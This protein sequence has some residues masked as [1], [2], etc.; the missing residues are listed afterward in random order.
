[1]RVP[2]GRSAFAALLTL[3][4]CS[5]RP[6]PTGALA[7]PVLV[8]ESYGPAVYP[9]EVAFCT[10]NERGQDRYR[11]MVLM[12]AKGVRYSVAT[13]IAKS[14]DKAWIFDLAGN[15]PVHMEVTLKREEAMSLAQAKSWIAAHVQAKWSYLDLVEG[16]HA[17]A[18]AG[19][20]TDATFDSILQRFA[21]PYSARSV[22]A[23]AQ[24]VAD[25]RAAEWLAQHPAGKPPR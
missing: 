20:Q 3:L 12:D 15:A 24:R 4:G 9:D 5:P 13:A 19:L 2:V 17:R 11:S 16:G 6:V 14:R 8:L 1:V 7:Y 10:T 18:L 22:E 23:E 21:G 25:E